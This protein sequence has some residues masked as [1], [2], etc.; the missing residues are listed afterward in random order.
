MRRSARKRR[1]TQLQVFPYQVVP[2]AELDA[3]SRRIRSPIEIQNDVCWTLIQRI[4]DLQQLSMCRPEGLFDG[5]SLYLILSRGLLCVK[6]VRALA[7]TQSVHPLCY[8]CPSCNKADSNAGMSS[9]CLKALGWR[10]LT[11]SGAKRINRSRWS[12]RYQLVSS[13]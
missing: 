1:L 2:V 5:Q 8:T 7:R 13:Q 3:W 11:L 10:I 9:E 4:D 12:R 6:C